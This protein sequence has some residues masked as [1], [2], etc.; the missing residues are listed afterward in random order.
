MS[1]LPLATAEPDVPEQIPNYRTHE[2]VIAA[3]AGIDTSA[4]TS[5]FEIGLP[6][7]AGSVFGIGSPCHTPVPGED[8]ATRNPTTG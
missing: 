3:G 7:V 8:P 1:R 6:A 5:R 2:P 4:G